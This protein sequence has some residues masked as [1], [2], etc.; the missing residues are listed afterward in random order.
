M[1]KNIDYSKVKEFVHDA[2]KLISINSSEDVIRH[3]LSSW[4]RQ[5]FKDNPWWISVHISGSETK[6]TYET[7]S[8]SN[9]GF[10]DSLVGKTVI[11][12]EKDLAIPSIFN[13]GYLQVKDYCA[14]LLND[15]IDKDDI[16]GIL[17]DTIEWYAY[18]ISDI[19][20]KDPDQLYA[21]DMVELE[22][23]EHIQLVTGDEPEAKQFVGF[24]MKY[25][26]RE[27]SRRLDAI[28]LAKD[29]GVGSTFWRN[30]IDQISS[31][32]ESA[33]ESQKSYSGMIE[34]L[35]SNFISYIGGNSDNRY[36]NL[37]SYINEFYIITIAKYLCVNIL[38]GKNIVSGPDESLQILNGNYFRKKGLLNLVEYDYF[39]WIN[40]TP[41]AERLLDITQEIQVDLLAYDFKDIPKEDIFGPL[42]AQLAQREQRLLLGQEYTPQWLAEKIVKRLLDSMSGEENPKFLDM[43]CGSGVFLVE[44]VK[45][46]IDRLGIDPSSC[47][48]EDIDTLRNSIIGFDIDPLAVILS[49][50]N[51]VLLMRDYITSASTDL[52]IPVFHADSLFMITPVSKNIQY[53]SEEIILD[54]DGES[55]VLPSFIVS[56]SSGILFDHLVN[57]C[58]SLA[59]Q[60]SK[61][62]ISSELRPQIR[63]I[64]EEAL[65]SIPS[66]ID[67]DETN[68]LI[69]FCFNLTSILEKMQRD[70]KNGIWAFILGNTYRPAL[71]EGQFN[72]I[73]SNPPWMTMSK[74]HN[75]PYRAGLVVKS[76][77]YNIKPAGGAHHHV[78]L[79]TIFLIQSI[80][81]YLFSD[82]KFACVMPD[83]LLNGYHHEPFRK[84]AYRDAIHPVYINTREIWEVDPSTFKNKAIV[85]FG[86]NDK[87][88]YT[89]SVIPGKTVYCDKGIDSEYRF[90]QQGK[91]SAW[92]NKPGAGEV[93]EVL[94]QIPFLQGA[95]I[96][97]RTLIFHRSNKQHNGKWELSEIDRVNDDLSYLVKGA[98]KHKNF[99]LK[100]VNIDD[101]LMYK[102]F[103]SHHVMPFNVSEPADAFLPI[104]R[105]LEGDFHAIREA[106]LAIRGSSVREAIRSLT[107]ELD[108]TVT[109]YY[110]KLNYRNKLNPQK[111]DEGTFLILAGAGGSYV[112]SG[113]VG[114]SKFDPQKVI[115][116]QTLYWYQT[117]NEDEA[118]YIVGLLN[119]EALNSSIAEFQPEGIQGRRH[120]HKLPY[121]ITPKYDEENDLHTKL[122]SITRRLMDEFVEN[123][124]EGVSEMILEPSKSTLQIRRRKVRDC[125]K[126]L[127][128]YFAYETLCRQIYGV[129]CEN[130]R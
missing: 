63:A 66:S 51:W 116:D 62:I 46:T 126:Q 7:L 10:V 75:N 83:S 129:D 109:D 108:I 106:S 30:Y 36:F 93:T 87:E 110:E 28:N 48:N 33:F 121:A 99:S 92:S 130:G 128:S 104:I 17:S 78:E 15:G 12:Y 29:M 102:C 107:A 127:P 25:V 73:V 103:L 91:R 4:M 60:R 58:C 38:E 65:I 41:Y 123:I 88:N 19:V 101:D 39:G 80:E 96:M 43:C 20:E 26:A 56:S 90:L 54:F 31:I 97:P 18:K 61:D 120:I 71:V 95:D 6:M 67:S 81:R 113:Y 42:I 3:N 68:D 5:M 79:A 23:V 44:T 53:G 14:G 16:V 124:D 11:E 40:E 1:D 47:T 35:W 85:L 125:L 57:M 74:L 59:M 37:T 117:A 45:Q 118:L 64:V 98:K 89:A 21:Q 22:E 8:G 72:G 100:A 112:C 13:T 105:N 49:K 77:R 34:N 50:I 9:R 84:E 86:D 52:A 55:V 115:V 70:G 119:S 27:G 82:S 122:V 69:E 114:L 76:T 24:I 94:E 111:F 32:I 2:N